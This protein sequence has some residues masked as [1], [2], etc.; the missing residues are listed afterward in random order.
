[1]NIQ[2]FLTET[3]TR[4]KEI[5]ERPFDRYLL[6]PFLIWFAVNSKSMGKLPRTMLLSAGLYQIFYSWNNYQRI[7]IPIQNQDLQGV[8]NEIKNQGV[9]EN[10]HLP[11]TVV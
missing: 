6:G 2:E 5:K 11:Y 7:A 8:W 3:E 10:G 9:T 4:I 1:M